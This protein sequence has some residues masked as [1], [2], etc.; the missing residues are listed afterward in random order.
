MGCQFRGDPN[1]DTPGKWVARVISGVRSLD[2]GANVYLAISAMKRNE[3]G[4]FRRRKENFRGGVLLMIDDIGSGPGSKFPASI[5]DAAQPTAL[6]ETSPGNHQ[7]LYFF[8]SLVTDAH[9]L[10]ALINGFI[11]RQFLGR[12][13]GM[14]GINRVFRPPFGV[15][16]KAKYGGWHVRCVDW[17]PERRYSV[18][19]LAAAFSIDLTRH[20]HVRAP[21]HATIGRGEGMKA[22]VLVRQALRGAGMLKGDG[23]DLSGWQ[24]V[25]CP[26]TDEHTDHAD[27]G[28]AIREPAEENDWLGAFRCHHGNCEGRGWKALTDWLAD[29]QSDVLTRINDSAKPFAE[30]CDEIKVPS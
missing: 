20:T 28:A 27:N 30:F 7:A 18:G 17:N 21:Q 6:V 19:A 1:D 11:E 4:E 26:W 22:F 12:D 24:N 5:L 15:N 10:D 9:A 13:T 23:P 16:G 25:V 3:R 8:D 29:H 14:A 2:D